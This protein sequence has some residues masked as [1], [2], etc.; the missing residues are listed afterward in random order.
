MPK[1]H[2]KERLTQNA[3]IGV[4]FA[5]G[6]AQEDTGT[7]YAR[8]KYP[9]RDATIKTL[10]IP[11]DN[12]NKLNK[13][14]AALDAEKLALEQY[15]KSKTHELTSHTFIRLVYKRWIEDSR[16]KTK[17]NEDRK[18]EGNLP[19]HE[20]V[21]GR[22]YWTKKK[23]ADIES[24]WKLYLDSFF[25]GMRTGF[26]EADIATLKPQ[27][28]DE[29]TDYVRRIKPDIA[30]STILKI[31][32]V[33]RHIYRRAYDEGIV[34]SIPSIRRPKRQMKE[35]V[36]RE[37][38]D[39]EYERIVGYTRNRYQEQE[40]MGSITYKTKDGDL[41]TDIVATYRDYAYLFHLW[42]LVI[43]NSGIRPPTSGTE[44]TMMKWEH[45]SFDEKTKIAT[46]NRPDEKGHSY[47]A[48]VMYQAVDYW[49]ALRKFQEDRGIESE[50]VFAHPISQYRE[51]GAIEVGEPIKTFAGA[52][53][54]MLIALGLNSPL[55][56][57]QANRLTPYSLRSYYITKRIEQGEVPIET[58]AKS[59]GSNYDQLMMA[60]YKFSTE[61]E[62]AKI[63]RGGYQRSEDLAPQYNEDGYY[64]GHYKKEDE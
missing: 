24:I 37:L 64:I 46:L 25:A 57:I 48:A 10:G 14:L 42:I 4:L 43:A 47:K 53:R 19:L 54:K 32:T 60:Y 29:I 56:T 3:E 27:K 34:S 17:E 50:Y 41:R 23:L 52:W 12:G 2:F 36:R 15:E 40:G 6:K 35:R 9:K 1:L 22:G 55:G 58:L 45:Y 7:W 38:T 18:S 16:I 59:V 51:K 44:N 33:I 8:I 28:L 5:S 13:K 20:V 26:N 49:N 11:Y 39:E 63:T 61:R 31:I 30:P 21:G 62:R